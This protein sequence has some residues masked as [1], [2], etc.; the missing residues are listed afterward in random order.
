MVRHPHVTGPPVNL[1]VLWVSL[2]AGSG[3]HTNMCSPGCRSG[4]VRGHPF[5]GPLRPPPDGAL[6]L[7]VGP[8]PGSAWPGGETRGHGIRS[9]GRAAGVAREVHELLTLLQDAGHTDFRDARGP[10]GF[11]QRQ[12]AGKFTATKRRRSS[13][14][15]RRPSRRASPPHPGRRTPGCRPPSRCCAACRPSSWQPSCNAAAGS[16]SSPDP[17]HVSEGGGPGAELARPVS[18]RAPAG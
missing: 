10:M 8:I 4:G 1:A 16:S 2:N 13:P 17:R 9:A 3:R 7:R 11:T 18:P 14:N 5:R 15:S 6:G 12:A